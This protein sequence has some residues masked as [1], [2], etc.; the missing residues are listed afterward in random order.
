M[1]NGVGGRARGC[2]IEQSEPDPYRPCY[3]LDDLFAVM[4]EG[5]KY[6]VTHLIMHR[7]G[8]T[9]PA[10]I[11]EAF[12]ASSNVDTVA[13]ETQKIAITERRL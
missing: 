9:D 13:T 12:Q 3:V 6:F 5:E 10:R 2:G 1:P 4:P 8:E 7:A 11:C